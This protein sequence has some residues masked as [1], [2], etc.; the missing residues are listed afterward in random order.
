MKGIIFVALSEMIQKMYGHK[1]WNNFLSDSQV[2]SQGI[3]TAAENYDDK[4]ADLLLN[5]IS[6]GLG[7]NKND[8]LYI[9]GLYLIKYYKRKYPA[10]FAPKNFIDFMLSIDKVVHV[11][12]GR[13][14]PNSTP[15]KLKILDIEK[16]KFIMHY[17]SKRKLCHLA[18][19]LTCGAARIY[20]VDIECKHL[21]CMHDGKDHCVFEVTYR[22]DTQ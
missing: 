21:E 17:F 8:I 5:S 2:G 6:K 13:I 19:G 11:E 3:Y 20:G 4:E 9:F 15:P 1:V 7:K 10:S 16:D 22:K 14:S 12:I 18:Q